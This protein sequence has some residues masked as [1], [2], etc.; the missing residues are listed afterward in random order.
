M[1]VSR[2]VRGLLDRALLAREADAED[3]RV[4]RLA[5]TQDGRRLHAAIVPQ[6]RALEAELL[7]ALPEPD[8]V[9]LHALL[10]R[11]D[12]RLTAMGAAA[13]SAGPD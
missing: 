6:A 5:M 7:A 13:D 2:A 3:R 11:L 4:Q 8:R 10:D 12:A 1:K 9:A